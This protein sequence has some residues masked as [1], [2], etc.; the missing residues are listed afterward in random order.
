MKVYVILYEYG[1]GEDIVDVFIDKEKA[2][3]EVRKLNGTGVRNGTY[4]AV[5]KE[6]K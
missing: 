6:L 5:E 4:S 2:E 3:N 1:L